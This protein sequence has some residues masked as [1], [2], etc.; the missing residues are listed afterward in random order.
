LNISE[1]TVRR[2]LRTLEQQVFDLLGIEP[3]RGRLR[4][5][6]R[7]HFDCCTRMVQTMI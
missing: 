6:T 2:H 7:R 5:W 4:L 1:A 3:S